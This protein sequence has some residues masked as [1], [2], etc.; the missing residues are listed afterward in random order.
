MPGRSDIRQAAR[1]LLLSAAHPG[2]TMWMEVRGYSMFPTLRPADRAEVEGIDPSDMRSG[3]LAVLDTGEAG[4][5][6]HRFFGWRRG[7]PRSP[8]TKGDASPRFDPVWLQ[9]RLLGRV[10]AVE[11][12]GRRIPVRRGWRALPAMARSILVLCWARLRGR[13]SVADPARVSR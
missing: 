12:A 11:R 10:R 5:I 2:H 7:N 6:I 1:D 9:A 13:R 8:R 3:D 4:W